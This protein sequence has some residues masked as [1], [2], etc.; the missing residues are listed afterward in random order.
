MALNFPDNPSVNDIFTSG[1]S[2]WQWDGSSWVRQGSAG[3]QGATGAAGAAGAQGLAGA[4][5]AAGAAGA[6]GATGAAGAQGV[7]G[8]P[9]GSNGQVVYNSGG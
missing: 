1:S 5:G 8:P 6:Q 9:A 3:A 4:Q 2:R 7:A